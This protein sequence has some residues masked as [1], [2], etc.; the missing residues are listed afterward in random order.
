MKLTALA[1]LLLVTL[2]PVAWADGATPQPIDLALARKSFDLASAASKA[3][4]GRLWGRPLYGP[5]LIVDPPS[6]S[7]VANQQDAES[8]LTESGGLFV[9]KLP[10]EISVANTAQRWA[11]TT[12]TMVMMPLARQKRSRSSSSAVWM[13]G[14]TN[15]PPR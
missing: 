1:P 7:V 12:W 15:N 10:A 8:L 13:A 4:A 5:L 3:D 2:T 6:R 11:G 14:K 9:G